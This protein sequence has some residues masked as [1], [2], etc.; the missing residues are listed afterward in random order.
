MKILYGIDKEEALKY[1]YQASIVALSSSCYKSK[2][3][4]VI[5]KDG[6]VI[7]RGFNS[8]PKNKILEH[9]FKDD[10]PADFRSDKTCCVHAEQR[11]IMDALRDNSKK[12][13]TPDYTL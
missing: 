3:G 11:A 2:C 12:S 4:S 8:P 5:V 7:G 1:L 13:L 9:C 6:E 10:L